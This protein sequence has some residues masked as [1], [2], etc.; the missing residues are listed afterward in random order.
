MIFRGAVNRH[1]VMNEAIPRFKIPTENSIIV[2]VTVDVGH[3]LK[4]QVGKPA[5]AVKRLRRK[6]L[7]PFM[8]TGH[9]FHAAAVDCH[10][11]KR[12]LEGR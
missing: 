2:P 11:I 7:L 10:P 4:I 1:D 6:E 5:V 8:G 12:D 9:I 3:M